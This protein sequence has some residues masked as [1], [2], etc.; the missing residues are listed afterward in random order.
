[1]LSTLGRF[2]LPRDGTLDVG[3]FYTAGN[4]PPV[5]LYMRNNGQNDIVLTLD[6]ASLGGTPSAFA[7]ANQF[8]LPSDRWVVFILQPRQAVYGVGIGAPGAIS[9]FASM[10]VDNGYLMGAPL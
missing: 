4:G 5:Q 1:M 10:V 2:N 7:N 3:P 6:S 9:W 8:V